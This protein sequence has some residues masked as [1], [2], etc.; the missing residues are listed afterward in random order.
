VPTRYPDQ[1]QLEQRR[2]VGKRLVTLRGARSL[3]QERLGEAVG[4]DRRT[5]GS[6]ENGATAPTLDDLTA[7]ARA[8]DVELWQLVYV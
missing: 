2:R 4:V 8:F 3:S 7:L 1:L 5:I 6:W